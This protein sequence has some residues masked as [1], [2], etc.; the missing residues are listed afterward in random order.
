M[1]DQSYLKP[2]DQ[3]SYIQDICIITTYFNPNNYI[4]KKA[5]FDRFISPLI[6]SGLTFLIIE[7]SFTEDQYELNDYQNVIKVKASSA[8]WQKERLLN[9][10]LPFI[11]MHCTK[12]VWIDSDILFLNPNWAVETSI[13]LDCYPVV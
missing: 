9:I 1:K 2:S 8:I 7:C 13:L 5:N 10:A 12:I 4:T 3:Y 6:Q 11:P